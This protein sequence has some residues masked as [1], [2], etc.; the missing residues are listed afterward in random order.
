MSLRLILLVAIAVRAVWIALVPV[1]PVSDSF[2]YVTF[3]R[4]LVDH[5]VYGWEP[6]VPSAFWPVG[7]SAVV[8]LSF[9]LLGDSYAG[10][11]ALNL[12]AGVGSVFFV[13]RLGEVYFGARAAGWAAL[14]MAVWPNLVMFTTVVSSELF[15]IFLTVAGLYLW[16]RRT[17]GRWVGALLAGAVW[18]LACYVRPVALL[19]PAALAIA[20]LPQ[21]GAATVRAVLRGGLAVGVM[22]LLAAPWSYRNHVALGEPVFIA[23]NFGPNLWMGNN[24]DSIGEYT[25]LPEWTADMREIE[26]SQRLKEEAVDYINEDWA[27]F[28]GASLRRLWLLHSRETI[29]VAWNAPSLTALGGEPLLLALKLVATGFWFLVLGLAVAGLA[30][31]ALRQGLFATLFHPVFGCWAYF[32]AVHAIIV[33]GD[34]Y[35]MPASPFIALLAGVALAA[36]ARRWRASQST[37]P[38]TP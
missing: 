14:A 8:A 31:G 6:E 28:A 22:L 23:T 33:A 10:V 19:I 20:A 21:G 12:V 35:H 11:V 34:R 30:L 16:E 27:R 4:T 15:F 38:G 1:E 2:A 5:G 18:G 26:W 9:W 36:L 37:T 25:P 29:G 32:S 13:H 7:T 24:P 3:A 17:G